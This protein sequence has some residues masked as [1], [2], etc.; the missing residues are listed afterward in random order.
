[1]SSAGFIGL[2]HIGKPMATHWGRG[3]KLLIVFDIATDAAQELVARGARAADSVVQLARQ[4]DIIGICVRDDAQV[5]QLLYGGDGI[6]DNALPNTV[7]LIHSTVTQASIFKWHQAGLDRSILVID[8]PVTRRVERDTFC[9]ILGG[10]PQIVERCRE[11]LT[12][13]G[14][15]IVHAGPLGSGIAVKLCNNMLTY[16]AFISMHEASRLTQGFGVDTARLLDVGRANGMLPPHV[17]DF[18]SA[19]E[20]LAGQGEAT[21]QAAFAPHAANARKDLAAALRSAQALGIQLPDTRQ[22]L[23]L[24]EDAFLRRP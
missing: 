7:V 12:A 20:A 13:G 14:N 19:R 1:M 22:N 3:T 5:E 8:A 21:L 16:A 2:G 4:C 10:A 9:Y 23:E 15:T 18:W 11:L 17:V 24:I 6:L